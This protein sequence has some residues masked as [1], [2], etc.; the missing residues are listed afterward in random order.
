MIISDISQRKFLKILKIAGQS[1]HQAETGSLA[2]YM[3]NYF[4]LND[5]ARAASSFGKKIIPVLLEEGSSLNYSQIIFA[6]L[7][8]REMPS[9]EAIDFLIKCAQSEDAWIRYHATAALG[10]IDHAAITKV[11]T[12]LSQDEDSLVRNTAVSALADLTATDNFEIFLPRLEDEDPQVRREAVKAI[13]E[14][15]GIRSTDTLIQMLADAQM[16]VAFEAKRALQKRLKEIDLIPQLVGSLNRKGRYTRMYAVELLEKSKDKRAINPLMEYLEICDNKALR[17][18]IVKALAKTKQAEVLPALWARLKDPSREVVAAVMA[19]LKKFRSEETIRHLREVCNSA[20][21][22]NLDDDILLSLISSAN[23]P[24]SE[25]LLRELLLHKDTGIAT[26]AADA[27][28]KKNITIESAYLQGR[29]RC[30]DFRPEFERLKKVF[31]ALLAEGDNFDSVTPP[32]EA[33]YEEKLHSVF[34]QLGREE[35]NA[36][37]D[38]KALEYLATVITE[39]SFDTSLVVNR[40]KSIPGSQAK[41]LLRNLLKHRDIYARAYAAKALL[42][43]GTRLTDED[44]A[45]MSIVY[46]QYNELR[47]LGDAAIRVIEPFVKSGSQSIVSVEMLTMFWDSGHPDRVESAIKFLSGYYGDRTDKTAFLLLKNA[48]EEAEKQVLKAFEESDSLGIRI[49]TAKLLG[50]YKTK[51]AVETL[52]AGL[53]GNKLLLASCAEALGK[54]KD[55]RAIEPLIAVVKWC[56]E[57]PALNKVMD[58]LLKLKARDAVEALQ[59]RDIKRPKLQE[60]KRMV[61]EK[62]LA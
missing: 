51:A 25:Q 7:I 57:G 42:A 24:E 58:A 39:Y 3:N 29:L 9:D 34:A 44:Y 45:A 59:V 53:Q 56:E 38:E 33:K 6:L 32:E 20:S 30:E 21:S 37:N 46:R 13:A 40:L 41:L 54:I 12:N 11:L 19:G 49:E 36:L 10:K 50:H 43:K 27:L 61:I 18:Q 31:S 2:N 47:N 52:I 23:S 8:L 14:I 62:L 60:K 22:V 35:L 1:Q 5:L 55:K 16:G 48:K 4:L 26:A 28:S 15:P 17:A